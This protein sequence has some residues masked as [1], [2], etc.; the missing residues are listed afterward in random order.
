M[1]YNLSDFT[2]S[3]IGM[4]FVIVALCIVAILT[5]I[6]KVISG[7]KI[8]YG[9]ITNVSKKQAENVAR[10]KQI[11]KN[12][13]DIADINNKID[14]LTTTLTSFIH[15]NK[16]SNESIMKSVNDLKQNE[17]NKEIKKI[18]KEV[19][20]FSDDLKDGRTKGNKQFKRIFSLAQEYTHLIK[21]NHLDNGY[22]ETE[23]AYIRRTYDKWCDEGR[24]AER[25]DTDEQDNNE[26]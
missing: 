21:D 7:L 24:F 4:A 9:A 14:S 13:Q 1:S 19:L 17:I 16:K 23:F 20:D 6:P 12:T 26:Y 11:D 8:T 3:Q 2:P 5:I 18:R 15:E 10:K 25:G 22:F